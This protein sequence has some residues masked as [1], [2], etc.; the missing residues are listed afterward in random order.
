MQHSRPGAAMTPPPGMGGRSAHVQAFGRPAVLRETRN[1]PVEQQLV[2]G[3]FALE[4]VAFGEAD[5]I[6]EFAWRA[7]FCVQDQLLE[8]WRIAFDLVD[9][10]VPEL[11]A[12]GI[13]PFLAIVPWAAR[14][15]R[16]PT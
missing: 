2:H 13:G 15:A 16:T 3:Q 6:F 4:N 11:V 10:G 1:G 5:L 8:A 9:Y 7:H 14:T 12:L